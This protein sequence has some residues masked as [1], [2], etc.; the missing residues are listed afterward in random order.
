M[1]LQNIDYILSQTLLWKYALRKNKKNEKNEK[2]ENEI[3]EDPK[4]V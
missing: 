1:V 4:K 2:N 3:K